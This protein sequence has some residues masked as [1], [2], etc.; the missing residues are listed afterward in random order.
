MSAP[1]TSIKDTLFYKQYLKA[2]EAEGPDAPTFRRITAPDGSVWREMI[3]ND[4]VPVWVK[5]NE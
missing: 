1:D 5:E 2:R 4:G 3:S